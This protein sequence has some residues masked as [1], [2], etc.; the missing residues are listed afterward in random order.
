VFRRRIPALVLAAV[1][2]AAPLAGCAT[3]TDPNAIHSMGAMGDSITRGFDACTFLQDC[4]AKSWAT[5]TDTTVNSHFRR[6][7]VKDSAIAGHVY[8]VAKTGATS[9]DLPAQ[10]TALAARK[11]D[12]VTALMGANDACADTE[13]AMTPVATFRSRVDAA[14]T[15]IDRARPGTRVLVT[16]VPDLYRLWQ[17]GHVDARARAIWAAGFCHTMLDAPSSTAPADEARRQRVRARV[18][19]YNGA[20]AASCQA[21]AGCR[22]DDGAVFGNPFTLADLSPFDYF[23][24]NTEGQRKLAAVTWAKTGF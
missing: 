13:A 22:Y 24:P 16:S 6:L 15:T 12:Y 17:V 18:L 1:A 11:P 4:T 7:L 19:A 23:H 21:H 20:L 5:G 3:S 14:L 9:A 8:N 10:A 2:V